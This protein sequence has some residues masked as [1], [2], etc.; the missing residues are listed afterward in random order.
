MFNRNY[1]KQIDGF[2]TGIISKISAFIIMQLLV[3]AKKSIL[4]MLDVYF[5]GQPIY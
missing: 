5:V 1:A 3:S 4:V 2:M